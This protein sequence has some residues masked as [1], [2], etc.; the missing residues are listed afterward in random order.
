MNLDL[1]LVSRELMSRQRFLTKHEGL[2][3]EEAV[4]ELN[5]TQKPITNHI[6]KTAEPDNSAIVAVIKEMR[7]YLKQSQSGSE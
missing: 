1:Q 2:T 5:K 6:Q 7:D 3:P 4:E